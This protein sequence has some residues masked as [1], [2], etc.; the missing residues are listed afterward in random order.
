MSETLI[1]LTGSS[2]VLGRRISRLLS[3]RDK[4]GLVTFGG[5]L[6]SESDLRNWVGG[7]H[8]DTAI[9]SGA[10]VP[11]ENASKF[12]DEAFE[13][14]AFSNLRIAYLMQSRRGHSFR[15]CY[16]STSHVYSDAE[17]ALG[18]DS[19]LQPKTV[20]G[21]SKLLGERLLR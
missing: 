15:I 17:G 12:P 4:T 6:R 7:H 5:D 18:E 14:N 10:I 21:R 19:L 13:V 11:V 3:Q 8:F 20:Y 2:G 1:G 9:L 16:I